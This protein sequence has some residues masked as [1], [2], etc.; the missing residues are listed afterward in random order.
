MAKYLVECVAQY[1][2]VYAI[3]TESAEYAMDE[4]VCGE[5]EELGQKYLGEVILSA[6]SVDDTEV[7]RVFDELNPWLAD[8]IPEHKL[9]QVH[10]MKASPTT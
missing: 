2:M 5:L 7:I 9:R 10:V 3:E 8:R 6:R 4:V 1:R